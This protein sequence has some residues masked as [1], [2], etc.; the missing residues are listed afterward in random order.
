M[1]AWPTIENIVT[2]LLACGLA[3]GFYYYTGSA[4]SFWWLLLLFNM[5]NPIRKT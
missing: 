3:T 5:N 4:Y 2:L 1:S